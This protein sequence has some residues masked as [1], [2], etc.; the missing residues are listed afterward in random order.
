MLDGKHRCFKLRLRIFFH[1]DTQESMRIK[2][3]SMLQILLPGLCY[4]ASMR[5][6]EA[7]MLLSQASMLGWLHKISHWFL[8]GSIDATM[9]SIDAR[10]TETALLTARPPKHFNLQIFVSFE[11]QNI[12]IIFKLQ[13]SSLRHIQPVTRLNTP[14]HT[15]RHKRNELTSK[16]ANT[17]SI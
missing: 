6:W 11:L 13:K 1:C 9:P 15:S 8:Y 17:Y 14:V 7:S 10:T 3:A 16:H 2:E 4:G 12:F 5:L